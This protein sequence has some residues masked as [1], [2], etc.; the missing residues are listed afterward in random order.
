[1]TDDTS[2][3]LNIKGFGRAILFAAVLAASLAI[4]YDCAVGPGREYNGRE[5]MVR[6]MSVLRDRAKSTPPDTQALQ[7]LVQS[8]QSSEASV[9]TAAA[10]YLGEINDPASVDALVGALDRSGPSSDVELSAWAAKSLGNIGPDARS[11]V[12]ALIQAARQNASR[13]TGWWSIEAL[14]RIADPDDSAVITAMQQATASADEQM[15]QSAKAALDVLKS[16]R[17]GIPS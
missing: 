16:R 17:L 10:M 1:M 13:P 7:T 3:R 15:R 14:G 6:R 5:T 12:P 8:L 4:A 2:R 9:S 11:A